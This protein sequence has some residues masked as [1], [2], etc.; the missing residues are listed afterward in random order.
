MIGMQGR[1]LKAA[2][3]LNASGE[4]KHGGALLMFLLLRYSPSVHASFFGY[5][6]ILISCVT[7]AVFYRHS[8]FQPRFF[9]TT[10]FLL[11]CDVVE[12]LL[13]SR[14]LFQRLVGLPLTLPRYLKLVLR[15]VTA[16]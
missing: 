10:A 2:F 12:T 14:E 8:Y 13:S 1:G 7:P 11:R 6:F 5:F 4:F 3:V 15:Q 16:A 9:G